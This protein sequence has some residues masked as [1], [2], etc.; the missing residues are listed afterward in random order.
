[1]NDYMTKPFNPSELYNKITY[2]TKGATARRAAMPMPAPVPF[3]AVDFGAIDEIAGDDYDFKQRLIAVYIETLEECQAE[4]ERTVTERNETDLRALSHKLYPTLT[5]LSAT[6]LLEEFER[7]KSLIRCA[8]PAHELAASVQRM[9]GHCERL[10]GEL[11]SVS[12]FTEL[13]D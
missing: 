11:E 5:I 13:K 6:A 9:K 12:G 1:M 3:T 8:A 10:T 7:G 4:Y 2:Y